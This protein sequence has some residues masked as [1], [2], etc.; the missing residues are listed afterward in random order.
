[1]H[2]K[3][4][5]LPADV[6]YAAVSPTGM[7]LRF[8][9][10]ALA[11]SSVM[12]SGAN[13]SLPHD[14]SIRLTL[15][16]DVPA[17][18][19]TVSVGKPPE[20]WP[21]SGWICLPL[22]IHQP[23]YRLGRLGSIVDPLTDVVDGT[24][25]H[26]FWLSSGMTVCDGSGRGVGICPVDSPLISLGRPGMLRYSVRYEPKH[27]RVY[28][29]LFNNHWNTNFRS[30]WGGSWTSR[31]RLWSID[32]YHA[33]KNLITPGWATRSPLLA[34]ASDGPAGSLPPTRAGLQLSRRGV[35]VT[36]FGPNPDGK[37]ILLR[38]WEH[39]GQSGPCTVTLP[40]GLDVKTVQPTDLRGRPTGDPVA[41]R[42]RAFVA[43]VRAYGPVS[44]LLADATP[45]GDTGP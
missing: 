24:N 29:N 8:E 22:K 44:F 27:P 5:N 30:W 4:G 38:L 6:P 37:G 3:T 17:A 25:F 11:V 43:D 28:V 7:T 39:A 42:N 34:A 12:T 20:T 40:E 23:N 32:K 45:H 19:L 36:A 26:L 9:R 16:Q 33:E 41:V 18:D 14:V 10:D 1:M 31:V 2:A 13:E 35:L 15:Y 21:E